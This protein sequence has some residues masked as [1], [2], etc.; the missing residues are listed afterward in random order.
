MK[1]LL[2][3]TL[4]LALA[5]SMVA[6][7]GSDNEDAKPTGAA[8]SNIQFV[9]SDSYRPLSKLR[10]NGKLFQESD[11]DYGTK[12]PKHKAGDSTLSVWAVDASA[13][14]AGNKAIEYSMSVDPITAD[15]SAYNSMRANLKIDTATGFIYQECSGFPACYDN[16]T[17]RD[18]DFRISTSARFSGSSAA[19]ERS[20]VLRVIA[21]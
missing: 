4:P 18:Q 12:N 3:L 21:N 19:L 7:G 6:C 2:R 14:G 11:A 1:T 5:A 20:F 16:G 9:D 8:L 17:N 15:G 13:Q 10:S